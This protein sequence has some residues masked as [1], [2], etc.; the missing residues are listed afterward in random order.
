M[1][2]EHFK[3]W[4]VKIFPC[5]LCSNYKLQMKSF[6]AKRYTLVEDHL[7]NKTNLTNKTTCTLSQ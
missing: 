7:S 1:G 3:Y 5:S 2:E 4:I 6:M